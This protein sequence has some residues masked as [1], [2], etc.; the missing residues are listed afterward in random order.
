M[1]KGDRTDQAIRR[2]VQNGTARHGQER[3]VQ[4]KDPDGPEDNQ[5][6]RDAAHMV[7]SSAGIAPNGEV[8]TEIVTLLG[9]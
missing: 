3:N 8:L 1:K 7:V 2:P 9:G 6:V 5:R 4:D